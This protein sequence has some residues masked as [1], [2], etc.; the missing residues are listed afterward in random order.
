MK[1][2]TLHT[3]IADLLNDYEGMKEILI[4]INP[5]FE[6]LNNPVLRRTLAKVASVRQAA[7]VGGMKPQEL[8]ERLRTAVGQRVDDVPLESTVSEPVKQERPQWIE[9]TPKENI[10]ANSLLDADENPLVHAYK[11]AKRLKAGETVLITS[12]FRPEPL[13]DEFEK[14]GYDVYCEERGKDYF[15]TYIR[16]SGISDER[17]TA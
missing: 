1:T 2:I 3:K 17:K 4:E 5:K 6:K 7:V 8:L 10:D 15:L 13:I 12:D 14:K 11:S 16:A 9:T